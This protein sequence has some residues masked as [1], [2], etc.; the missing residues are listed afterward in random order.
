MS[1]RLIRLLP[2]LAV[3]SLITGATWFGCGAP[4]GRSGSNPGGGDGGDGGDGGGGNNDGTGQE[5]EGEGPI[6]LGEGEEGDGEEGEGEGEEGEGEG[7][8]GEGEG[9]ID[10]D[11]EFGHCFIIT[12]LQIDLNAGHDLNGDGVRDNKLGLLGLAVN[13]QIQAEI[14]SGKILLLADLRA[15]DPVNNGPFPLKMYTG[16]DMDNDPSDNDSGEEELMVDIKSF[17][18]DGNAIISF[19]GAT[20]DDRRL[21]ARTDRFPLPIP[22]DNPDGSSEVME[23]TLFF[24]IFTGDVQ[25]DFDALVNGNLG[26][27]AREEDIWL[28]LERFD[29]EGQYTDMAE[30]F[31]VD[32]DI[33]TD[34]DGE[35]DAFSIGISIT[36]KSCEFSDEI[37]R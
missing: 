5:G 8:E 16:E 4:A 29:P 27:A 36:A 7:A 17:D 25:G 3:L 35:R 32:P 33:D 10:L 14:D 21:N 6:P 2:L 1:R 20:L 19:D 13:G 30:L 9:P 18:D 26:G 24:T 15:D 11:I 12:S 34:D 31:I 23:M 28:A 22:F 37:A